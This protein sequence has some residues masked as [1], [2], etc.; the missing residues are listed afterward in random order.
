M[1]RT[2]TAKVIKVVDIRCLYCENFIGYTPVEDVKAELEE[3]KKTS[4]P[5]TTQCKVCDRRHKIEEIQGSEDYQVTT[6]M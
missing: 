4:K 5:V 1:S 6:M 2:A 3:A